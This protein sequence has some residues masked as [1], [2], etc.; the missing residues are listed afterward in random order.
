MSFFVFLKVSRLNV[1]K[2][3]TLSVLPGVFG[4]FYSPP[5][6]D[7]DYG[8]A[9]FRRACA[10]FLLAY[11]R[12]ESRSVASSEGY[13]SEPA[14]N[15]TPEKSRNGPWQSLACNWHPSTFA[16]YESDAEF[17]S[18]QFKMVSMRSEKPMCAPPRL[19]EVSPTLPLKQFQ[20]SSD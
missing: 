10:I 16:D 7:M 11:K 8:I 15:L 1:F 5:N 20:C 3:L 13:F 17:S 2:T 18:V 19:S 9:L 6:S 4:C 12:R 14:Q